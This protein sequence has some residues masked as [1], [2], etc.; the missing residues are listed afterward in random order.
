[1]AAFGRLSGFSGRLFG[2]GRLLHAPPSSSTDVGCFPARRQV[3]D[4]LVPDS[5]P[6]AGIH[7]ATAGEPLSRE[8]A[9]PRRSTCSHFPHERASK[10]A[11]SGPHGVQRGSSAGTLM[12]T[13]TQTAG[14]N[15]THAQ[16]AGGNRLIAGSSHVAGFRRRT[17]TKLR[18]SHPSAWRNTRIPWFASSVSGTY[19]PPHGRARRDGERCKPRPLGGEARPDG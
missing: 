4:A 16:T 15:E 5:N 19:P 12:D 1:M 10:S 13:S 9:S 18:I 7:E 3:P 8:A 2:S 14:W 17:G 11:W 6:G